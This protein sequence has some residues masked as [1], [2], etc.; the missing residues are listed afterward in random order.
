[1]NRLALRISSIT[2]ELRNGVS[3]NPSF[4]QGFR[5]NTF[6]RLS[7]YLKDMRRQ[8]DAPL[9][10]SIVC[11]LLPWAEHDRYRDFFRWELPTPAR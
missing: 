2:A 7:R 10:V 8:G 1:M 5:L 6:T 9:P 3:I 11:S 4:A